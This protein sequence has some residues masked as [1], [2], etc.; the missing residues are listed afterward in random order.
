MS[1]TSANRGKNKNIQ[2]KVTLVIVDDEK[3][4]CEN[5]S[6]LFEATGEIDVLAVGY[7]GEDAVRLVRTHNPEVL[8]LDMHYPQGG[9]DGI[10]VIKQLTML[11]HINTK[12]LIHTF[13]NNEN[14]I[15]EAIKA[16]AIS[17]VW[18]YEPH[19]DL[20]NAVLTT[21][22]GQAYI[23]PSVAQMVLNFFDSLN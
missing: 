12:I 8:M 2:K 11:P 17:Y 21:A 1:K 19:S 6:K 22:G 7:S 18:K 10:E 20:K 3:D 23:S 9:I 15:F 16:G 13:D 5:L 4:I 14:S